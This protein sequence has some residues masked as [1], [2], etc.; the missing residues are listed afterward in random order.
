MYGPR[1]RT[2]FEHR[3]PGR[4]CLRPLLVALLISPLAACASTP[5]PATS[6]AGAESPLVPSIQAYTSGD[7]VTLVLQV[8]NTAP[9]ALEM[10]FPTGQSY[11]FV[12][13]QGPREVWRWSEGRSFTQA[14]RM[15]TVGPGETLR[16]QEEWV[17]GEVRGEFTVVGVLASSDHRVEQSTRITLP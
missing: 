2:H 3:I 15:E 1:G 17:P 5:F 4:R 10:S 7:G 11:D 8:L 14:V 16:F 6:D 9:A 12:V 13:R